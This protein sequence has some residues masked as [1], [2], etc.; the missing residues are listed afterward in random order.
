MSRCGT[1]RQPAL[2]GWPNCGV[3]AL[4]LDRDPAT[5]EITG[6][7]TRGAR[8]ADTSS[9]PPL[10]SS[11]ATG[12]LF[13]DDA[14]TQT[15]EIPRTLSAVRVLIVGHNRRNACPPGIRG[16]I[17]TTSI[18]LAR[19]PFAPPLPEHSSNFRITPINRLCSRRQL[20]RSICYAV[21]PHDAAMRV[22]GLP[23][24]R[25]APLP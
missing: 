14:P 9:L 17:A 10:S 1:R 8:N 20:H 16:P 22:R 19:H 4:P 23:M 13:L 25:S 18:E 7:C 21:R 6:T 12:V 3:S 5:L 15:L 2:S 24:E 11:T